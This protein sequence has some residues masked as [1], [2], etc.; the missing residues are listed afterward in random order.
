MAS[1]SSGVKRSRLRS[2]RT[3]RM[4][5]WDLP[6]PVVPLVIGDVAPERVAPWLTGRF[7]FIDPALS[8][9]DCPGIDPGVLI[10][11]THL[12]EYLHQDLDITCRLP[13]S[14]SFIWMPYTAG[15]SASFS[16]AACY[17]EVLKIQGLPD[18]IRPLLPFLLLSKIDRG[19]ERA[20]SSQA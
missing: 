12:F 2:W 6:P 18:P 10:S 7:F 20:G 16:N 11:F 4:A 13:P 5:F 19:R 3:E 1:S 8:L 9:S 17:R 14:Q 15:S